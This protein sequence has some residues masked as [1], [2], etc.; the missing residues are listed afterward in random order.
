MQPEIGEGF[1]VVG[2]Q[3]EAAVA[4]LVEPLEVAVREARQEQGV[5]AERV[6]RI[7]LHRLARAVQGPI[8]R[9]RARIRHVVPE[10][11]GVGVHE[12]QRRPQRSHAGV[13]ASLRFQ[14][15]PDL[16]VSRRGAVGPI[17]V[18]EQEA[19]VR[20]EAL[21]RL[22]LG[23]SQLGTRDHAARLSDRRHHAARDLVLQLEDGGRERVLLQAMGSPLQGLL[24]QEAQKLPRALGGREL[25]ARENPLQL[26]ANGGF[27][28]VIRVP[29]GHTGSSER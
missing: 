28:G 21:G 16:P 25:G 19:V 2:I 7:E 10:A 24:H 11:P 13:L 22:A 20:V 1:R 4:G 27:T 23:G 5:V 14:R 9:P 17:V 26:G 29:G 8:A 15:G 18:E 12:R 6:Q 3:L